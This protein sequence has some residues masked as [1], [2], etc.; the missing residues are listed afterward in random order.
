MVWESLG[1]SGL[2]SLVPDSGPGASEG[3]LAEGTCAFMYDNIHIA[4]DY[5]MRVRR[6]TYR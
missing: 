3:W 4:V 6:Q 5:Q 2:G 1:V